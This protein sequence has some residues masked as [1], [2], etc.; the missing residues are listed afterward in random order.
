M[1]TYKSQRCDL[2][3]VTMMERQFPYCECFYCCMGRVSS[4]ASLRAI[5]K[6]CAPMQP[7]VAMHHRM[8]ACKEHDNALT[9]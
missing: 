8:A 4:L 1:Q 3:V 9:A 7:V 6:H 5:I 2:P